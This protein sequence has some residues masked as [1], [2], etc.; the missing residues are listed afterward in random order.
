MNP[1]VWNIKLIKSIT[2]I[3]NKFKLF[4]QVKFILINKIKYSSF[5]EPF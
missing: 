2:K 3:L 4:I 1:D 5:K